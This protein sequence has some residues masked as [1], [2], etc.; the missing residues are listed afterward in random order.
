MNLGSNSKVSIDFRSLAIDNYHAQACSL[1][2]ILREISIRIV[3][4]EAL[5]LLEMGVLFYGTHIG[6]LERLLKS[7]RTVQRTVE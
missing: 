7:S 1:G 6:I 5:N 3:S 4:L 2:F